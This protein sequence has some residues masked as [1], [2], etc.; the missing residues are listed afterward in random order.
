[1]RK[2]DFLFVA[3]HT[4]REENTYALLCAELRE[5][6]YTAEYM[7][8]GEWEKKL[9]IK[10]RVYISNTLYNTWSLSH[11][12][13][14]VVGKIDKLVEMNWEQVYSREFENYGTFLKDRQ[15]NTATR[16][17]KFCWGERFADRMRQAGTEEEYLF[18]TGHPAFDF[19]T[20][21]FRVFYRKRDEVLDEFDIDK[22]KKVILYIA[23]FG[24]PFSTCDGGAYHEKGVFKQYCIS[25]QTIILD[26][27]EE[28]IKVNPE[29]VVIY[30][31]HPVEVCH[32]RLEEMER[33]YSQFRVIKDYSVQQWM[34]IADHIFTTQSTSIVEAYFLG[35]PCGV[36]RPVALP[37]ENDYELY[38]PIIKINDYKEFCLNIQKAEKLPYNESIEKTY[39]NRG[40][41][42]Y[43]KVCDYLELIYNDD[44]Q[45]T[46]WDECDL[47]ICKHM[48]SY[49]IRNG[50]KISFLNFFRMPYIHAIANFVI[51]YIAPKNCLDKRFWRKINSSAKMITLS[52]EK[53]RKEKLIE[54]CRNIIVSNKIS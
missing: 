8:S 20:D 16:T 32:P 34:S 35:I 5:R 41:P 30:R 10:P 28:F 6:G 1:M 13:Y 49:W 3:E 2:I 21:K 48:N 43:E 44:N 7:L 18:I 23:D 47:I 11:S 29:Y 50:L 46:V 45:N 51:K 17:N 31:P 42:V 53:K 14:S 22:R 15:C 26:W 25:N 19:L 4:A 54:I 52:D 39:A 9:Y 38:D 24:G 40:K 33:Q 12:L 36:L 27:F 37:K